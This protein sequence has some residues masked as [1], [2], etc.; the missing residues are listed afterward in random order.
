M[1]KAFTLIELLIVVAIIGILAAIAVPNFLN[2]QVRAK[3]ARVKGDMKALETSLQMYRIDHNTFM[4]GL[5][6]NPPDQYQPLTSPVAY[7]ASPPLDPFRKGLVQVQRT[8]YGD[9][10]DFPTEEI[11]YG[12]YDS[13]GNVY[14]FAYEKPITDWFLI[15]LG[16]D[17][18]EDVGISAVGPNLRAYYTK[19][20]YMTSNG[21]NSAG[22]LLHNTWSSIHF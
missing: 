17:K 11:D 3:I 14:L 21:L 20:L 10:T 15:S 7:I 5:A 8:Y 4:R 19:D 13:E 1:K 16:P 22:D 2:A 18:I 6:K 9:V 12:S